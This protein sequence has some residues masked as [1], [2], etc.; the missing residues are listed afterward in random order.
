M[1]SLSNGIPQKYRDDHSHVPRSTFTGLEGSLATATLYEKE[2]SKKASSGSII[3]D[4]LPID[5]IDKV[6]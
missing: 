5:A 6:V 1:A 2:E 3:F 4:N